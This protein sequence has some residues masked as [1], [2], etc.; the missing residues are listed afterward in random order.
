MKQS[1]TASLIESIVNI[2]VGFGISLAAQAVFMPL[3]G[4]EISLRQN[5]IFAVIMTAIS[6][7][8][9]FALRR[10]FE[11]LHIRHPLSPAMLAVI[12]ERRRQVEV[13]G[14]TPEH[15]ATHPAGD[16][17]TAGGCYLVHGH[18]PDGGLPGDW[19]WDPEW[20]KPG[21]DFRRNL[22]KG[23]ALGLAEIERFDGQRRR[24]S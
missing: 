3:L 6:I 5:V 21:D 1:R 9:S 15:D 2:V 4:V 20:W 7:A 19:P 12:A 23:C 14:W 17:A 10:L 24:P 16:L 18:R 8:R 11:A 22:V 13:E